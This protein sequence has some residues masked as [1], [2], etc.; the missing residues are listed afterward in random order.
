MSPTRSYMRHA[1]AAAASFAVLGAILA[2]CSADKPDARAPALVPAESAAE[3]EPT[4]FNQGIADL[5]DAVEA[6]AAAVIPVPVPTDAGGGYTHEQHKQNAKTIYEAGMLYEITGEEKYRDIAVAILIDYAK[7]YPTLDLH[8]KRKEGHWPGRLFWQGLNE[9]WWLV[10]TIQGY[11]AIRDDIPEDTREQ[12]EAKL[13]HPMAKF[14][15]DGSERTFNR[16]HNHATWA[17]AAVGM[18]GYVLDDQ[19]YI[20]KAL[21]GLDKSGEQGFLKQVEI[22][23]SPDGYYSEGPYY[24][25]Y[26]L[27]PYVLFAQSIQRHD[28]DIGIFDYKDGVLRK[29]IISTIQQSYGGKFF[30][31]NDAIREKGL[32]TAELRYAIAIAYDLTGDDS[33]LSIV[34][35]YQ[36]S[37]VPT[38]EGK[39]L[40]EAIAAGREKPFPYKS[41][42]LR[43]GPEGD[44][45]ALIILRS[46]PESN[47]ATVVFKPTSQGLGHGHFD[48]L[49]LLY[50]DNGDEVIADYGA[51]RFLNVEPKN[52][53]Q[54]LP[55]N[56]SWAKQTIAHN[57]LVVDQSSQFGG[58]WKLGEEHNPTILAFDDTDGA[59]F[60]AAQIATAYDG[61]NLKRVI[62]MVDRANGGQYIIDIMRGQ[63][64][65]QHVYD[66]PVHFK[67]QLIETDIPFEHSTNSLVPLGT[68]NGYQHLWRTA[69]SDVLEPGRLSDFS[70]L[71]RDQ[72]YRLTFTTDTSVRSYLTRLGAADPNNNLR[73]EQ[74]MI[75]RA[76]GAE[77]TF[78]SV[79]ERFG[80][81][82][83]DEEVTVYTRSSITALAID[84]T[85]SGTQ[86][87]TVTPRN[88]API[89]MMV[90]DGSGP[91]T[92]HTVTHRGKALS[93]TGPVGLHV[94]SD[95]EK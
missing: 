15:S 77:A 1:F 49:G 52:G 20:D 37:I 64:G 13:F 34:Q 57:T 25:R 67:G 53:G 65:E 68:E 79:Y 35:D 36:K 66:L 40:S 14:L 84:Q 59:S 94:V 6:R 78:L 5:R 92:K 22:L 18:T 75:L 85:E 41:L 39:A 43:D 44:H 93:W 50:Y 70:F 28:P 11:D 32:N 7:L 86:I 30:P 45:G 95:S 31:I 2:A 51:A 88:G 56:E 58:D 73:N 62:A 83:N 80:R 69:V 12:L 60:A 33:L 21:Y 27:M 16:I 89:N 8:P 87:Y 48:R 29:A 4:L 10:Y 55:E 76:Q 23:F 74:A 17:A 46:G 72:F 24:Q 47:S 3:K 26:A 91:D 61:V 81:Y 71:I 42:M 63:S 19:D 38:P 82:D 90:A 9:A 54:Y